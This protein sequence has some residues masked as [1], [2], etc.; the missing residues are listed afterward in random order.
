[1]KIFN[2]LVKSITFFAAILASAASQSQPKFL[3]CTGTKYNKIYRIDLKDFE[4][5]KE[6][7]SRRGKSSFCE[8]FIIQKL[9]G[10]FLSCEYD[11]P[12]MS[13]NTGPQIIDKGYCKVV[14]S[15]NAIE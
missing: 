3:E 1:M 15:K 12:L 4:N 2:T 11:T 8:Y 5:T 13:R 10:S 14:N 7:Y 6:S 9:D